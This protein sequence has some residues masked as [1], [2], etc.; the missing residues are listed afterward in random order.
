METPDTTTTLFVPRRRLLGTIFCVGTGLLLGA[1]RSDAMW[2]VMDVLRSLDGERSGSGARPSREEIPPALRGV[3][4]AQSEAYAKFLSRL[5]LRRISVRQIIDSHAKARGKVH[6][7][8]PPRHLWGNIRNT[9][10]VLDQVAA[11]LGEPVGEVISVYRSPA[12]NALCPGAKSNSYHVRNNA[13]D[14]RF[15]SPPRR[16]A[17]VARDM[18]KQGVFKGGVGRYSNFTHI[19]TRGFNAD[20]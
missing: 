10:K 3:L 5:N 20:W 9:L 14:V 8:I 11:R 4:G 1:N 13:I 19:D 2:S 18:K 6:N 15:K 17:A 7:T 16:V 12:Y